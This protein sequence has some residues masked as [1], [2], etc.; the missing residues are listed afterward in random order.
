MCLT[1]ATLCDGVEGSYPSLQLDLPGYGLSGT[2]PPELGSN[3]QL[4]RIDL[5]SNRL[6][7]SLP[8]QLGNLVSLASLDLR[9]NLLSYPRSNA[10]RAEYDL[11]TRNCRGLGT[12]CLGIPPD[13]CSAFANAIPSVTDPNDCVVCDDSITGLIIIGVCV[14]AGVIALALFVRFVIR[15][16]LAMKRWVSSAAILINHAQ[17]ASIVASMRLDWP[18]SL[19]AIASAL[20]FDLLIF[21]SASCLLKASFKAYVLSA[22]SGVLVLLLTPI[23]VKSTAIQ[24]RRFAI[25]DTAELVLSIIY[26][27]F[28]TFAFG[29]VLKYVVYVAY[30]SPGTETVTTSLLIVLALGLLFRFAAN[31]SAFKHGVAEGVWQHP[32]WRSTFLGK[33]AVALESAERAA[34]PIF[35]RRLER[36]VAYLVGRFARHAPRWQIIIWLRQILLLLLVFVSDILAEVLPATTFSAVRYAVASSA[37]IVVFVFWHLHRRALPFAYRF[38]N[39]L[40]SCLYG[41]TTIIL[42][43]AMVYTA[44]PANLDAVRV[45]VEGVMGAFLIGSLVAGAL[46]SIREL[47]LMRHALA[48]VDLFSILDA[49]DSKIDSSLAERLRDGSVRLLRC[50]WLA[51]PASDAFLGRE[52]SAATIKRRQDL[53]PEAFVPCDEAV[54]ML[55]RGDRSVLALSY[56]W[57]TALHPDPHGTTLAAVR[58]FLSSTEANDIGLFWDFCSLPQRGQKG[59][60]RSEAEKSVFAQGLGIMGSIYASVTGTAVLQQRDIVLPPGGAGKESYNPTPYDG[61]GGRG[62]CIF[63]QGVAMTVL[64]HLAAAERQQAEKGEA[65]PERFRRAQA[66]RAKVYDIGGK[67]RWRASA[68][69]RQGRCALRRAARSRRLA[70]RARPT[71]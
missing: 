36:Q 44:L 34:L 71:R 32:T 39:A 29:L 63:E 23:F 66:S 17:M 59:E 13:S 67:R 57:L 8:A 37:M 15:Y 18:Y 64:A 42:A 40:E 31:V 49:A 24:C 65:M 30:D 20:R 41:A 7:G 21:P 62:W 54:A 60:E 53:P 19:R 14:I 43:L 6:S 26:S 61:D 27:L 11:A 48:G 46:W 52:G 55:E 12:N 70:S 1:K 56:G 33:Q 51:S 22:S 9:G 68:L 5:S 58:R 47:R 28:F 38:Q 16:P 69:C 35:P 2:I 4:T 10:A 45:C 25:A 50:S 3:A